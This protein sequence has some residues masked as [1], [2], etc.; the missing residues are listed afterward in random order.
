MRKIITVFLILA[1]SLGLYGCKSIDKVKGMIFEEDPN[2]EFIRS[3]EEDVKTSME[4]NLRE[5]ITYYANEEGYLVP[6]KRELPWE[7]GIAKAVLKN[8]TDS[9]AIR[10]DIDTIGLKPVIPAQ[11]KVLGMSVD[12][13]SGLCKIDFSKDILNYENKKQEENLVNAVVYALTE[14]PNIK[15]VQIII[16][17]KVMT[18]LKHGTVVGEPLKRADINLIGSEEAS[19]TGGNRK[20]GYSKV[21]VYYKGTNDKKYDYYVPITIPVSSPDPTPEMIVKELFKKPSDELSGLYT[22]I[23][24]GVELKKAKVKEDKITLSLD[25][26]DKDILEDKNVV[27]RMSKNIGLTLKQFDIK[28]IELKV[29][30]ETIE[31]SVPTFANEY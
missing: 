30:N 27:S 12:E 16:E 19:T 11:T 3:D 7:E 13:E 14:F 10:E 28:N 29:G 22:D 18:E 9:S 17:G 26:K 23:P 21:L 2:V 4:S 25:V 24:N 6:V 31:E 8:M 20:G 5:S 15:E 1:L